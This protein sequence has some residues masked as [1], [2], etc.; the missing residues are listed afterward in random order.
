M[1]ARAR[2]WLLCLAGVAVCAAAAPLVMARLAE[3][4]WL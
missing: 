4:A 3:R 2:A 1:T